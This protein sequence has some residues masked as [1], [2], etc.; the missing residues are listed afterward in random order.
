MLLLT[1]RV[2]LHQPEKAGFAA[3]PVREYKVCADG[4][5]GFVTIAQ[6]PDDRLVVVCNEKLVVHAGQVRINLFVPPKLDF[7]NGSGFVDTTLNHQYGP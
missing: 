1:I 7:T 2:L 6:F 4:R 3:D 5:K